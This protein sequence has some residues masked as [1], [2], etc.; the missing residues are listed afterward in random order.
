MKQA[1]VGPYAKSVGGAPERLSLPFSFTPVTLDLIKKDTAFLYA[2]KSISTPR[3]FDDAV[4]T[5]LTEAVLAERK[6]QAPVGEVTT[7]AKD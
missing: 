3:L 1:L 2:I 7:A 4:V 6:L 5:D